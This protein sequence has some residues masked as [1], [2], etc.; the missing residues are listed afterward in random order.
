MRLS[1]QPAAVSFCTYIT[2]RPVG[3][4][5]KNLQFSI[6]TR[7]EFFHITAEQALNRPTWRANKRIT[8]NFATLSNTGFEVLEACRLFDMQPDHAGVL[9]HPQSTIRSLVKFADG[10]LL[11]QLSATDTRLSILYALTYPDCIEP[12]LH[13]AV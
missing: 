12:E 9:I 4:R 10:S 6:R 13:F 11:A 8:M 5:S 2:N 3:I 7:I 1:G